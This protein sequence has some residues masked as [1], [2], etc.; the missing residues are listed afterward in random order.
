M[1]SHEYETITFDVRDDGVAYLTLNRP[2]RHNAFNS[3]MQREVRDVWRTMAD[4]GLLGERVFFLDDWVPQEER[5]H[6]LLEADVGLTLARG[7]AET[8]VAARG[9]YMDY[10]WAGLPCVLG[11]G[12]VLA[13]RFADAG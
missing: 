1:A 11:A 7:T 12:D 2:E 8:V 10:V 4:M 9:R 3:L 6:Y 13:D 5:H